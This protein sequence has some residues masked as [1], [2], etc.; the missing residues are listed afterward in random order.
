MLR[1]RET[2]NLTPGVCPCVVQGVPCSGV[3]KEAGR[4][5][6]VGLQQGYARFGTHQRFQSLESWIC[7]VNG[8]QLSGLFGIRVSRSS[9]V[10]CDTCLCASAVRKPRQTAHEGIEMVTEMMISYSELVMKCN[11]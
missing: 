4:G 2:L 11:Q 6:R 9:R 8:L 3:L 1:K 10:G 5:L 7:C